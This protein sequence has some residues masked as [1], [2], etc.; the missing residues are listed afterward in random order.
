MKTDK[1][2]AGCEDPMGGYGETRTSGQRKEM[3][4][5]HRER[6]ATVKKEKQK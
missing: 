2:R 4:A 6:A 5:E 3:P 1:C